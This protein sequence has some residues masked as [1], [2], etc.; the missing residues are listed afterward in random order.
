MGP[1]IVLLSATFLITSSANTESLQALSTYYKVDKLAEEQ[2]GRLL[3]LEDRLLLSDLAVISSVV[4]EKR[5]IV[6]FTF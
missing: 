6:R 5:F 4:I 1:E 3:K 2:V